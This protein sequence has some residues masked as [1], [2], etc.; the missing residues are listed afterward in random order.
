VLTRDGKQEIVQGYRAMKRFDKA[1]KLNDDGTWQA[2]I[3]IHNRGFEQN[4]V[5]KE[6]GPHAT[7]GFDIAIG[8]VEA[9]QQRGYWFG[10][11]SIEEDTSG[12]GSLII[13]EKQTP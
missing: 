2:E 6:F 9:P 5:F 10:D 4:D 1:V 11:P 8:S 13:E 12:F 3:E 7:Y